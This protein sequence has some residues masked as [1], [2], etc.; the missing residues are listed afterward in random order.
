MLLKKYIYAIKNLTIYIYRDKIPQ[1]ITRF[2][3]SAHS[4]GTFEVVLTR[5]CG[6]KL[7]LMNFLAINQAL[8]YE[9]H[10]CNIFG[11]PLEYR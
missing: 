4:P 2:Y 6:A 5:F 8:S 9:M 1:V 7:H 11:N 3:L 10:Y